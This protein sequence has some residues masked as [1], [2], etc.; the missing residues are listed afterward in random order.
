MPQSAGGTTAETQSRAAELVK[1]AEGAGGLSIATGSQTVTSQQGEDDR[2]ELLARST[3]GA[4]SAAGQERDR[5]LFGES[6]PEGDD[7]GSKV[8]I[9]GGD[10]IKP[11]F[12]S[13]EPTKPVG[14]QAEPAIMTTSGTVPF[15]L[16][17][18][19][20][21][22]IP[23]DR[24]RALGIE[25]HVL[26]D[27]HKGQ[28][29]VKLDPSVPLTQAQLDALDQTT[30]RAIAHDRGYDIPI[31]GR[32]AVAQLFLQKQKNDPR[33]KDSGKLDDVGSAKPEDDR[34]VVQKVGDAVA[35]VAG[36]VKD[37]VTPGA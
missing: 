17:P 21:G 24:A 34:N 35:S 33:F 27:A 30:I 7:R 4:N 15:G 22:P 25:P 36:A 32:T 2:T 19:P 14:M 8:E 18:S 20:T 5:L 37:A 28:F 29:G 13:H 6:I 11:D 9:A 3:A 12:P 31:R 1:E 23:A 10:S 16:A 26:R